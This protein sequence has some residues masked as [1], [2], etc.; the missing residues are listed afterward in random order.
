M[1]VRVSHTESSVVLRL[2]PFE[3]VFGLKGRLDIPRSQIRSIEVME[4]SEIPATEGAW[5]RAPGTHIPGL[6]RYGSYGREPRREFWLMLRQKR[7]V[8]ITVADW[9][10]HRVIIGAGDPDRLAGELNRP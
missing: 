9:A 8:V 10:Y 3:S 2:G 7:A 1:G 6:I 5:L 4:R